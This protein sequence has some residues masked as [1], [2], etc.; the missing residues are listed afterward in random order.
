MRRILKIFAVFLLISLHADI[1]AQTVSGK[2]THI[3][4]GDS[5]IMQVNGKSLEI[6]LDGVDCPEKGQ[7][8]SAKSKAF[9][10]SLIYNRNVS[11]KIKGYDKYKRA[12]GIVYISETRILNEELLRVG[13]A[14]HFK[15]FNKMEHLAKMESKARKNR[16][17]LWDDPHPIPPW[18]YRKLRNNKMQ[19]NPN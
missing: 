18:D 6:R 14:W 10:A 12:L 15:R 2:V 16:I 7:P 19:R 13:L 8:F 1:F 17:G 3:K 9:S 4:D 5:F 11:V